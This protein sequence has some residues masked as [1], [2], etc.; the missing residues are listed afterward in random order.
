MLWT[1]RLCFQT[2]LRTH[3]VSRRPRTHPTPPIH[4]ICLMPHVVGGNPAPAASPLACMILPF[5]PR[6]SNLLY[7]TPS[8]EVQDF[9]SYPPSP[10]SRCFRMDAAPSPRKVDAVVDARDERLLLVRITAS[11]HNVPHRLP[12]ELQLHWYD[13]TRGRRGEEPKR[14]GGATDITESKR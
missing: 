1:Q 12:R 7:C 3:G 13:V 9:L 8:W 4:P 11:Y 6:S 14:R 5:P 2:S 10:P